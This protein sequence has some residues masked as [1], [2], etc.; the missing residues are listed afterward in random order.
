M[1]KA[2]KQT[3]TETFE[4]EVLNGATEADRIGEVLPVESR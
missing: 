2:L 4:V 1:T 3:G